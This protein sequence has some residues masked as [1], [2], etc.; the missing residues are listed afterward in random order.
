MGNATLVNFASG[1]TSPRSRG[2]FDIPSYQSSCR[3]LENFIAEVQGSA[4][5]RPG[6]RHMD[7]TYKNGVA[8]LVPYQLDVATTFM[9]EF[10]PKR[11]R[12]FQNEVAVSH[13]A[14]GLVPTATYGVASNIVQIGRA[15]AWT[16][17]TKVLYFYSD[18]VATGVLAGGITI[19][20]VNAGAGPP[21]SVVVTNDTEIEITFSTVLTNNTGAAIQALLRAANPL[22]ANWRVAENSV[23]AA[24]RKKSPA[25]IQ[26][27]TLDGGNTLRYFAAAVAVVG[28][29]E[30]TI[31]FP[32]IGIGYEVPGQYWTQ[33]DE[34]V[35]TTPYLESDLE[36]LQ[37]AQTPDT[38]YVTHRRH[39]PR[40]LTRDS[41]GRWTLSTYA[42]TNDPFVAGAAVTINGIT[43]SAAG[44]LVSFA[45]S[46]TL[47]EDQ[48]YAIA[49]V[50]GTTQLNGNSYYL[51]LDLATP[52]GVIRAWLIDPNTGARLPQTG[53]S[54]YVSDGTATPAA[55]NPVGVG[56]YEGRLFFL[57]TNRRPRTVFGSRS[58]NSTTGAPR[59]DDFTG[60]TDADHAVFFTLSP[61][62]GTADYIVWGGGTTKYLLVGA[63][64]GTFRVSGGGLEEPITPTSV[65]VR[66]VDRYGCSPTAPAFD[67]AGMYYVPRDER[68]VRWV[69][70][71]DD[72]D[73]LVSRDIC[74]NAEQIGYSAIKRVVPH[75][76]RLNFLWAVRDDGQLC[77]CTVEGLEQVTG[78]HRHKISGT[79]AKVLEVAVLPRSGQNDQL[80]IV[81]ERTVNG[82]TSR[83]IEIMADDVVFADIED[84][85][86]IAATE[87][88]DAAAY[89]ADVD[90][91]KKLAVHLDAYETYNGAPAT[92]I[93]GLSHLEGQTVT[94]IADG[95]EVT[96]LVVASG[97]VTLPAAASVVHVGLPYTGIL[98]SQNLEMGGKSG[99][100]QGKPRN[101]CA[102]NIRFLNSRGGGYGTDLYHLHDIDT[103]DPGALVLADG[104]PAPLFNGIRALP[105]ADN[106]STENDRNEKTVFV[107]QEKPYP[108]V[109]QFIDVEYE[110]GD[111]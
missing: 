1:E 22:Y 45:A 7:G 32:D 59:L 27:S 35:L 66:P 70:Y 60:G 20:A 109:V 36:T 30:H 80:Y 74:L 67:G 104:S 31:R 57:G 25:P 33:E 95:E 38:M 55:D 4:R 101:I 107:V 89:R 11:L 6:F 63:F 105:N 94:A 82:S 26:E 97:A 100:A 52:V 64:G 9:L 29:P 37:T 58:P 76:A 79:A 23:F 78:W 99:P 21:L 103:E 98:Q 83:S 18:D 77:G 75:S 8:R 85:Y 3:K 41:S 10:T 13:E 54:A 84:Y 2:R 40:K 87:A 81:S 108:L 90:T 61:L 56:L 49:A 19:T 111:E 71:A 65:K 69:Q 51:E 62:N 15:V 102:L 91:Q 24:D 93:S 73:E 47:Y 96:G 14:A 17:G 46:P 34:F 110:T 50:V 39:A 28:T 12:I 86:G 88:L 42:R 44:V 68:S 53:L 92:V 48:L 43:L 16:N 72:A 5:F 106:W